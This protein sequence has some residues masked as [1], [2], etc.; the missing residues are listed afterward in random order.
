M[1]CSFQTG[2]DIKISTDHMTLSSMVCVVLVQCVVSSVSTTGSVSTFN[3]TI[4][5][6]PVVGFK[7]LSEIYKINLRSCLLKLI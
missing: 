6:S 4:S 7:A 3:M 2:T 1:L 5:L